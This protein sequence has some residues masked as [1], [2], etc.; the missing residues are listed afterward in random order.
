M[1]KI[2]DFYCNHHFHLSLC[3]IFFTMFQYRYLGLDIDWRYIYY[4]F[5][6]TMLIYNLHKV[7][8]EDYN[9]FLNIRKVIIL[10][11]I[12][13]LIVLTIGQSLEKTIY[14]LPAAVIS[15]LYVLPLLP[16]KKKLN[17]F[18]WLKIMVLVV[19]LTYV[20]TFLPLYF[21]ETNINVLFL[22]SI[23]R[24]FFIF[25][26]ALLFDIR[27]L[28]KDFSLGIKTLPSGMG[29]KNTF[30]LAGF[31]L[32]M[33]FS[34]DFYMVYEFITLMPVFLSMAFT[35]IFFCL[36]IFLSPRIFSN[37]SF[38]FWADNLLALPFCFLYFV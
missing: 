20:T 12:G 34:L 22:V 36:F 37:E 5:F 9:L 19:T 38:S 31:L 32:M 15:F 11:C 29:V 35:F 2:F 16:G 14:L 1:K 8:R 18:G 3:L 27:D 21:S 25:T 17:Q 26:L 13:S 6:S 28:E 23:S 10:F 24:F 7:K 4:V 33:S 30:I